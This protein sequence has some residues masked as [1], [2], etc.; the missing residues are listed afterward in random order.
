MERKLADDIY[1]IKNR[2]DGFNAKLKLYILLSK[3][4]Q[5]YNKNNYEDCEKYCKKVLEISNHDSAAL[6]GLGCVELSRGHYDNAI[7]FYE[8]ALINSERKEVEH[9]LIGMVLYLQDLYDD[10]IEHFNRA[11]DINDDFE[12][13]YEGKNQSMLERH[14]QI[15]DFQDNLIKMRLKFN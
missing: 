9:T 5:E 14:V 15:A 11:I 12:A 8:R 10:A 13:A 7:R 4:Q 3:A 2:F 6:R 1:E